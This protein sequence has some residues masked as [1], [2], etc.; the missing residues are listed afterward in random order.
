MDYWWIRAVCT[1]SFL[2]LLPSLSSDINISIMLETT[3]MLDWMK[4]EINVHLF[5]AWEMASLPGSVT[6]D[7][8]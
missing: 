4:D 7:N 8:P 6:K 2:S 1:C 5:W 3:S